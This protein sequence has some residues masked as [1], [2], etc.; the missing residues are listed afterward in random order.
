MIIY[1]PQADV[2]H[3][4]IGRE[5]GHEEYNK[6][7]TCHATCLRNNDTSTASN[8]GNADYISGDSLITVTAKRKYL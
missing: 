4:N 2:Q 8:F 1:V 6:A 7:S 3:L 5:N